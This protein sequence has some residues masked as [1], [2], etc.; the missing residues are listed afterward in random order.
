MS[1]KNE[2]LIGRITN[3]IKVS[4]PQLTA[5]AIVC[6]LI[7][8]GAKNQ[9]IVAEVAAAMR[10]SEPQAYQYLSGMAPGKGSGLISLINV[11]DGSNKVQITP[12]GATLRDE[13]E[14]IAQM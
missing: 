4:Y 8:A 3:H 6:F 10:V 2:E 12:K 7:V 9:M 13:V 11:G 14:G 1:S 5:E